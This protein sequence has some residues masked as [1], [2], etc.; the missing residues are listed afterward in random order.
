MERPPRDPKTGIFTRPVVTLIMAGGLSSTV[1]NLRLV[2]WALNAGRP[3]SELASALAIPEQR[4]A[5]IYADIE[6]KRRTTRYLHHPPVLM[7]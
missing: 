6:N 3:A 7:T 5:A 1:V 2:V 4:A